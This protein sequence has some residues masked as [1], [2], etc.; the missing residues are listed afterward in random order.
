MVFHIFI[1]SLWRQVGHIYSP[2][3]HILAKYYHH[4]IVNRHSIVTNLELDSLKNHI[5]FFC[6][7]VMKKK[8]EEKNPYQYFVP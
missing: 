4:F 5:Y 6:V 2:Q 7:T 8:K 3:P 1:F